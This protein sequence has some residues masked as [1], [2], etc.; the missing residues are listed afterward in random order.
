M[1]LPREREREHRMGHRPGINFPGV[2]FG[3][4]LKGLMSFFKWG[5][6]SSTAREQNEQKKHIEFAAV[7]PWKPLIF[8]RTRTATAEQLAPNS[9]GSSSG[10]RVEG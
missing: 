5:R 9:R 8:S 3:M 4:A 10:A 7:A 2:A 6:E 1:L